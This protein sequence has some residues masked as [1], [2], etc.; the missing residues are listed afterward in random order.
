MKISV[1]LPE[2]DVE[3]LANYARERGLI[4]RSAALQKAIS[5]LRTDDLGRAYD[6]AWREWQED[7][8]SGY[9][10]ESAGDGLAP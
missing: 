5:S 8:S 7:G 3:F 1:S 2:E 4:S 10:E 9:W 6:Q